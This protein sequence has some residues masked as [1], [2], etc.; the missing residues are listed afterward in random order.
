MRRYL[1][2]ATSA[3]MVFGFALVN[4]GA[5]PLGVGSASAAPARSTSVDFGCPAAG[6]F[7]YQTTSTSTTTTGSSTTTS[8]FGS[9][10]GVWN[11]SG[12]SL[13][14]VHGLFVETVTGDI[15]TELFMSSGGYLLQTSSDGTVTTVYAVS[16][17]WMNLNPSVTSGSC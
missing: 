16:G 15:A 1:R 2:I 4:I 17:F 3:S 8:T 12:A 6:L 7:G 13:I 5:T 9:W 11:G 14:R 10:S